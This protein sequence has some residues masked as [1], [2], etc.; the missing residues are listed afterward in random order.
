MSRRGI[1]LLFSTLAYWHHTVLTNNSYCAERV[2]S[3]HT[4]SDVSGT[5][6]SAAFLLFGVWKSI[7]AANDS[8]FLGNTALQIRSQGGTAIARKIWW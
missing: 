2:L 1:G 8:G 4:K 6:V 7:L 3:L 5:H